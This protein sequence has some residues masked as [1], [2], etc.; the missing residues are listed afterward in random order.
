M[1]LAKV[2]I[3]QFKSVYLIMFNRT[4]TNHDCDVDKLTT[5]SGGGL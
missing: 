5:S 1:T 3:K 2:A 4:F